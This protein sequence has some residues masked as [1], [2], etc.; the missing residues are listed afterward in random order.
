[1]L[2]QFRKILSFTGEDVDPTAT[3]DL[4]IE[5]VRDSF[6]RISADFERVTIRQLGW[7]QSPSMAIALTI[8]LCTLVLALAAVP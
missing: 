6:A 1:M 5:E 3:R 4:L 2:D 7:E 8:G